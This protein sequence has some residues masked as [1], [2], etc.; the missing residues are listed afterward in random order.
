MRGTTRRRRTASSMMHRSIAACIA[1]CISFELRVSSLITDPSRVVSRPSFT[2]HAVPSF[3]LGSTHHRH[4]ER[5]ASNFISRR[6]KQYAPSSTS[7][8]AAASLIPTRRTRFTFELQTFLRVLFP[9]ILSGT[10]AFLALPALC[11]QVV[12]FV[13]RTTDPGKI[14]MLSDAVQS[15]ISLVGLLYS[16][17][18]GQVFGFLYSQQ[19]VRYMYLISLNT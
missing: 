15:F 7:L 13:T 5:S 1:I 8:Q 6:R 2:N 12:N 4:D 18:M 10:T 19:E 14:G 9:A 16:I 11:L 17:L 3:S